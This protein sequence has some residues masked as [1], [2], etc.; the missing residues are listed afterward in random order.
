MA[1]STRT[2][3]AQANQA[4]E[5][6]RISTV[7]VTARRGYRYIKEYSVIR[8]SGEESDPSLAFGQLEPCEIAEFFGEV[9]QNHRQNPALNSG[10]KFKR[11]AVVLFEAPTREPVTNKIPDVPF[12]WVVGIPKFGRV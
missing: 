12:F 8:H 11:F 9:I 10:T 4:A 7:E 6:F 1:V 3:I 5:N 2:T